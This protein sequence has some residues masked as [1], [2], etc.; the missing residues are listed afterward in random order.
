MVSTLFK[1]TFET[2][3]SENF[4]LWKISI[5]ASLWTS[6]SIFFWPGKRNISIHW[7][8][9]LINLPKVWLLKRKIS[10][11]EKISE[12]EISHFP[13]ISQK[14]PT[15]V[16]VSGWEPI[17]PAKLPKPLPIT[18]YLIFCVVQVGKSPTLM[19]RCAKKPKMQTWS[20]GQHESRRK[21][22][23]QWQVLDTTVAR[24]GLTPF[25]SQVSGQWQRA[26]VPQGTFFPHGKSLR[27]SLSCR[28]RPAW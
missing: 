23:N 21:I 4:D 19:E 12:R 9:L 28:P 1:E 7:E 8:N 27:F 6:N 24:D 26:K 5:Q 15:R 14:G 2:I 13:T 18:S 22:D 25:L 16:S 17:L 3:F 10:L 20:L 11:N